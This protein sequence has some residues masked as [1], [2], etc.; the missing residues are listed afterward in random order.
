MNVSDLPSKQSFRAR[1]RVCSAPSNA[2]ANTALR[3]GT[4]QHVFPSQTCHVLSPKGEIKSTLSPKKGGGGGM[5]FFPKLFSY[6]SKRGP[7]APALTS[8]CAA[9]T[10]VLFITQGMPAGQAQRG[11]SRQSQRALSK[12]FIGLVWARVVF[13]QGVPSWMILG[14]G[15]IMCIH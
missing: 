15:Q 5:C 7:R 2:S 13:I 12:I 8:A 9:S 3:H 4:E 1:I 14:T 6:L 10:S 11:R